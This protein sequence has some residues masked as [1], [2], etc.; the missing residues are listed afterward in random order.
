LTRLILILVTCHASIVCADPVRLDRMPAGATYKGQSGGLYGEGQ[1]E[2]PDNLR[3]QAD[4]QAAKVA[5]IDGRIGLV[6][7]GM[8][9]T[10]AD[11]AAFMKLVREQRDINPNLVLVNGAQ[12]GRDSLAWAHPE[13]S[14]R[15]RD[16]PSPWSELDRRLEQ[17]NLAPAQVQVVW[18][19]HA[20]AGPGRLGD[21]PKHADMLADDLTTII[22]EA[23][24]RFV[25]VRLI[26]VSSRTY[27]GYARSPLNPEPYAY[28][29]GFAVRKA[30]LSATPDPA[31][32][33]ILW[34]PY[35]WRDGE[36][37]HRADFRDDGTHPSPQGADKAASLMLEFFRGDPTARRWFTRSS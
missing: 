34:G 35:L 13:Q 11:F 19:L 7:I 1:S 20:R 21:F 24:R 3:A 6:S 26:Y 4:A 36:F 37:W 32:P 28:E 5:P 15:N 12:G 22:A 23:R 17:A 14:R 9:N 25:N 18:M 16:A 29:S 33:A 27:G 10:Q 8:S 31:S 30:V 2:P